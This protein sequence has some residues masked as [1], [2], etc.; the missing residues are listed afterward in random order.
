MDDND[1]VLDNENNV[2]VPEE[3]TSGEETPT[4]DPVLEEMILKMRIE[5]LGDA[6]DTSKDDIFKEK[7]N[8]AKSIALYVLYPFDEE[9]ELPTTWRMNYWI[10]R[11][12]IELYNKMSTLN[13]QS[14]S[15]NGLSVSYLTGSISKILLDEL[16]P[17]A[18]VIKF[19]SR[20]CCNDNTTNN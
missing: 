11:C 1:E 19:K 15:E 3:D 13:V 20:C 17:K 2:D 18:G 6:T 7:I 14:Y 5:I 8:D 16:V 4:E 10:V 12:A 9:A